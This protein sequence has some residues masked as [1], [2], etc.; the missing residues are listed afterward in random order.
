MASL[1]RWSSV[2]STCEETIPQTYKKV[3][4]VTEYK[5][6][7]ND[8]SGNTLDLLKYKLKEGRDLPCEVILKGT[9]RSIYEY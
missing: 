1:I 9:L 2:D 6:M 8:D 4:N 3:P 5:L 7:I